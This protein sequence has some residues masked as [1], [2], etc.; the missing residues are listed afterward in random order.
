MGSA[1]VKMP[2]GIWGLLRPA[3][4]R[5]GEV[6]TLRKASPLAGICRCISC[7]SRVVVSS[8]LSSGLGVG[9]V[10]AWVLQAGVCCLSGAGA[11][12]RCAG[13]YVLQLQFRASAPPCVCR[14]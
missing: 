13:K 5:S 6:P 7:D 9:G 10:G 12:R 4:S 14:G 8:G 2:N 11:E 3:V 1:G